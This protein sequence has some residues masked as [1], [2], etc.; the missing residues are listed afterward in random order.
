[1]LESN[2][3]KRSSIEKQGA[4]PSENDGFATPQKHTKVL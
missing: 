3:V 4:K 2:L 1:M